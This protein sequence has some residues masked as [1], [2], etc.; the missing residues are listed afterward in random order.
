M[1][2]DSSGEAILRYSGGDYVIVRPGQFVT[3]AV[4]RKPIPLP[5]L[6]YWSPT[7]QEAYAGPREALSR[8]NP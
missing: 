5:V 8:L 1:A 4:S 2:Q 3:C 7:L 6:R